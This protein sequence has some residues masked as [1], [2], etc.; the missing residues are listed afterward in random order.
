MSSG[1]T[2]RVFSLL[3]KLNSARVEDR[4]SVYILREFALFFIVHIQRKKPTRELS[5]QLDD[6]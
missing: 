1:S 5:R 3:W 2:L 4:E 6:F